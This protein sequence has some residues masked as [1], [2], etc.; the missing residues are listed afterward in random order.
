MKEIGILGT[1][2]MA[3]RLADVFAQAGVKVLL[4][5]RTPQRAHAIAK[6][7][8]NAN[9]TGGTYEMALEKEWFLPAIFLKDGLLDSLNVHKDKLNGKVLLDISNAF[10]DTYDDFILD[11][12]TSASEEIQKIV[13]N[14]KIIGAFKNV[15]YEVFDEP[16]FDEG[17]SDVYMTSDY[18]ELKKELMDVLVN[19]KFRYMDAGALK[20]SRTIERMTLLATELSIRYEFFPRVNWKFLGKKWIQ[21]DKDKYKEMIQR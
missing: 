16:M 20:N 5:S 4:G 13:P 12:D 2:R 6:A 21:G 17:V 19:S 11:W 10:N 3:V 7:L 8:N 18:P 14:V 9:V 15:W 1:G